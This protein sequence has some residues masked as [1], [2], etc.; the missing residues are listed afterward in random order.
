[1]TNE[2][3]AEIPVLV[4][5]SVLLLAGHVCQADDFG[6]LPKDDHT[7]AVTCLGDSTPK[8]L[9]DMVEW[10]LRKEWKEPE[11]IP[12]ATYD[13]F[14]SATIAV[15]GDVTHYAVTI[16]LT[17][18][19]MYAHPEGSAT[20]RSAH[21]FLSFITVIVP[22]HDFMKYSGEAAGDFGQAIAEDIAKIKR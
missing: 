16:L 18:K 17:R 20:Y 4:I 8:E 12:F 21:D 13:V 2:R 22:E 19:I 1:M 7:V 3:V 11:N 10:Q 5:L 15:S 6:Y 14:V 9:C